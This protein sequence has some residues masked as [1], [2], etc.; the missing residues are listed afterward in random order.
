HSSDG[1]RLH[2]GHH[3]SRSDEPSWAYANRTACSSGGNACYFRETSACSYAEIGSPR[4]DMFLERNV[5][6][7]TLAKT[8]SKTGLS[9]FAL[10]TEMF[11]FLMQYDSR[12][13]IDLNSAMAHIGWD[14]LPRPILALHVRHGKRTSETPFVPTER[15]LE[16]L[17]LA[18]A[19]HG[20]RSVF[21]FTDSMEVMEEIGNHSEAE[22]LTIASL[23]RPTST[24]RWKNGKGVRALP[25]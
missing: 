7:G 14:T 24:P 2:A 6:P 4:R 22:E 9:V 23:D 5:N 1:Y 20:F 25:H 15:F 17:R 21:L 10:S 11:L 18:K 16:V 19:A 8:S 13:H 3:Q 12:L